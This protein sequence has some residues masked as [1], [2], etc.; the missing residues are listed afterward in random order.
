MIQISNKLIKNQRGNSESNKLH[1]NLYQ[2]RLINQLCGEMTLHLLVEI[3]TLK[4][5]YQYQTRLSI[6][7]LMV[8]IIKRLLLQKLK[9]N[10]STSLMVY[11]DLIKE[12]Y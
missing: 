12:H 4:M 5:T 6:S 11:L 10:S 3:K 9:T 1:L 7:K 8:K 2:N